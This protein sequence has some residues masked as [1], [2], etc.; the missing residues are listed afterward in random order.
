[1]NIVFLRRVTN[2]VRSNVSIFV[3]SYCST[4]DVL[5]LRRGRNFWMVG[6]FSFVPRKSC[7]VG[8]LLFGSISNGTPSPPL[9]LGSWFIVFSCPI[10]NRSRKSNTL[11]SS[12]A[13][14]LTEEPLVEHDRKEVSSNRFFNGVLGRVG[15]HMMIFSC[16]SQINPVNPMKFSAGTLCFSL[17]EKNGWLEMTRRRTGQTCNTVRCTLMV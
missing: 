2:H 7:M 17:K 11:R 14:L 10:Q 15:T 13:V 8:D 4:I 3:L 16:S 6:K 5:S 12:Y 1:M 9:S